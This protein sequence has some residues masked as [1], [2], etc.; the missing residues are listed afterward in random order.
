MLTYK[1]AARVARKALGHL[2]AKKHT[3]GKRYRRTNYKTGEKED[4][5]ALFNWHGPLRKY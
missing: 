1:D 3:D 2:E 4:L 5:N